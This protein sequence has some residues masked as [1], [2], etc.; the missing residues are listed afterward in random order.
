MATT[1]DTVSINN[2]GENILNDKTR[3][4]LDVNFDK[5]K[6]DIQTAYQ[7]LTVI[8]AITPCTFFKK[9]QTLTNVFS[10]SQFN[11]CRLN[12]KSLTIEMSMVSI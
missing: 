5:E 6:W 12:Q 2:L 9:R 10:L 7:K 3:K 4:L 8:S 11:Y 1:N